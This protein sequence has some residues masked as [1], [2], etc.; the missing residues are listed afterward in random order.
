MSFKTIRGTYVLVDDSNL[1]SNVR[2][3]D[4]ERTYERSACTVTSR[5]KTE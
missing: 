1:A 3:G 4:V 5:S 2:R